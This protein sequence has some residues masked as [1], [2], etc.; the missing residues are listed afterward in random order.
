MSIS[1]L[2]HASV[3]ESDEIT[4][5]VGVAGDP[6]QHPEYGCRADDIEVL[7]CVQAL[8]TRGALLLRGAFPAD[9]IDIYSN[10]SIRA[11]NLLNSNPEQCPSQY[12]FYQKYRNINPVELDRHFGTALSSILLCLRGRF[13][14]G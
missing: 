14:R 2:E 11:F 7:D 8:Q 13:E 12:S 4:D 3:P 6:E 10:E 1:E 5:P 9:I